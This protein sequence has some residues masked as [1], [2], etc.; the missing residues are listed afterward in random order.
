MPLLIHGD[1]AF[2]GQGVVAETLN[3]AGLEGYTTGGTI[4]VVVN[5]QIG[6]TT[7]PAGRALDPLL[8]R[9][10]A[11]AQGPGLPRER[12]GPGGGRPGRARSRS[13]SASGS[14]R[15]SSSTCTATAATATTRATSRA[16]RSR[17]CTQLIDKK[18]TVREVYVQAAASRWGRS[19]REQADEIVDATGASALDAALDEEQQGRLRSGA[20]RDGRRLDALPRRP[21]RVDRPRCRPRVRASELVDLA[22]AARRAPRGLQRATRRCKRVLEHARERVAD[23]RAASTGAPA[24]CSP[25]RSLARAKAPR[26]PLRAGRRGAARSAIATRSLF[27]AQDGRA[28]TRRSRTLGAGPGTLRGLRQ[29]ALRGGR[30]RLRVRLQPRLPRRARDLGGAV[31]RLR[32]TARRSSSTSSSS[33]PKTSGTA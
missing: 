10:H 13:S 22:D 21:R 20:A 27:D 29:P 14:A 4:H 31:R 19:R 6:F 11:H 30:A 5:N 24:R 26:P 32:R 15:T 28:A 1:A 2:M 17:S 9:H 8:H 25:S 23:G 33:P 18:P 7:H 3:L 16:S 12:R